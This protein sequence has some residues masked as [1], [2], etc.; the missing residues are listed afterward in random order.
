MGDQHSNDKVERALDALRYAIKVAEGEEWNLG[1]NM[2][3][4]GDRNEHVG[5]IAYRKM[6]GAV[7]E[8]SSARSAGTASTALEKVARI[9]DIHDLYEGPP[10]NNK[11]HPDDRIVETHQHGDD[12]VHLTL[13]DCRAVRAWLRAPHSASERT[14]G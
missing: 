12:V 14:D 5:L 6:L 9:A 7:A 2:I 11:R 4:A 1:E 3:P 8:L 13:G 10:C